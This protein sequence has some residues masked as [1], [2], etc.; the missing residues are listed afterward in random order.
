MR[1]HKMDITRLIS[2]LLP[3][4]LRRVKLLLWMQALL[5]PLDWL[6]GETRYKMQHDGRVI[7]L[8]K[9]LNEQ[10]GVL[11]YDPNDHEATKK[12][13]IGPGN[14]PTEVY[15]FL[16]TEPDD[17]P[18]LD[19]WDVGQFPADPVWLL[20]QEEMEAQYLDFTVKVPGYLVQ[21]LTDIPKWESR[22]TRLVDYYKLAGKEYKIIWT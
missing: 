11:A 6:M 8:E 12:I 1:W 19:A 21:Y 13:V 7:Y 15:I 3:L 18:Y 17:P 4:H 2:Q 10:M 20:T 14:L 22:I 16:D 5:R 9:V